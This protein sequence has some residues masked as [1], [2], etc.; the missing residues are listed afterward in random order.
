MALDSV[1]SMYRRDPLIRRVRTIPFDVRLSS[2]TIAGVV[3]VGCSIFLLTAAPT[4]AV[5]QDNA[6]R[7][8][9]QS[10]LPD[11]S[12]SS[13]EEDSSSQASSTSGEDDG[14]KP[15]DESDETEQA[16][17]AASTSAGVTA[18]DQSNRPESDGTSDGSESA[19]EQ[20][21]EPIEADNPVDYC[22]QFMVPY[23]E[24]SARKM[25]RALAGRNYSFEPLNLQDWV[26]TEVRQAN[27]D[28][29]T[30]EFEVFREKDGKVAGLIDTERDYRRTLVVAMLDAGPIIASYTWPK[31]KAIA[32][33]G[34]CRPLGSQ[35]EYP[36]VPT[37][38]IDPEPF[39]FWGLRVIWRLP[40]SFDRGDQDR[41][42]LYQTIAETLKSERNAD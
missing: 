10:R 33:R 17:H 41:D 30:V 35:L 42:N 12:R 15:A 27:G 5:G 6:S 13:D 16:S 38:D 1:Y 8:A 24:S 29:R 20:G 14:E 32:S 34:D 7:P 26:E 36:I 22:N 31:Q 2:L 18:D 37:D 19:D 28:T 25:Y 39:K 11:Q 9:N 23:M 4:P 21:R 40:E 3:G